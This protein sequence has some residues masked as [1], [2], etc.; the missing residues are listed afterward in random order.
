MAS[1]CFR[2]SLALALLATACDC[3][4]GMPPDDTF[5]GNVIVGDGSVPDVEVD[6]ETDSGALDSTISDGPADAADAA[7]AIP[8]SGDPCSEPAVA[9]LTATAA[10]AELST[11]QDMIVE[12]TGTAT[13][14]G[15]SCTN[16]ACP[17][18]NPCCNTCTA[19]VAI[20]SVVPLID[21]LCFSG[22]GCSG[23]ECTQVC[24]PPLLGLPQRFTGTLRDRGGAQLELHSVSN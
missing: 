6:A 4:E 10:I 22:A 16:R 18:E 23:N 21:G 20:D 11:W 12:I 2:L 3:G 14:T 15:L 1:R 7:D 19:T 17:P 9:V 13:A 5:D 24:R 8:D